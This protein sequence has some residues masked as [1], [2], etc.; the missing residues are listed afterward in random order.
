MRAGARGGEL[1]AQVRALTS[2][3][4]P[5]Q[6]QHREAACMIDTHYPVDVSGGPT[7]GADPA[8]G[9][10]DRAPSIPQVPHRGRGDSPLFGARAAPGN[11]GAGMLSPC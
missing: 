10:G 11:G 9:G 8:G 5:F 6:T 1:T 2:T 3:A 7:A 4:S